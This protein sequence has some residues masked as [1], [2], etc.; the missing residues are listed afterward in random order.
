MPKVWIMFLKDLI[1]YHQ[2]SASSLFIPLG[3][4][5]EIRASM[6]FLPSQSKIVLEIEPNIIL[7]PLVMSIF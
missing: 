1:A 6:M 2:V 5:F 4:Q 3:V 7:Y